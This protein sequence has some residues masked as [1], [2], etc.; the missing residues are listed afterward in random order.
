MDIQHNFEDFFEHA[1]C[2]Y[3]TLDAKGTILEANSRIAT[4]M[5]C[6]GGSLKGKRISDLLSVGGR[7]YYETHL[8]PL[9]RIQGYFDEISL[10]LAPSNAPRIQVLANAYER[11]DDDQQPLFIR[12]TIFKA[13]DRKVYEQNLRNDK[14]I[15]EKRLTN[16]QTMSALREQFI[17]VLGHDLRNPLSAILSGASFLDYAVQDKDE[18]RIVGIMKS[19]ARRMAGMIDDIMDFARGR[20]GEGMQIQ[21]V[22]TETKPVLEQVVNE[23]RIAYPDRT[24][25]TDF[26]IT[27]P[28]EC[29]AQRIGQ[30]LSNLLA[31]AL[32]H[33]LANAPV[34]VNGFHKDE[35]FV[36][37][38]SN[39]GK[40]IAPAALEKLFHPF[41][42]ESSRPTQHG[43]GL[44]LYIAAEIARAH[45]GTIT[46]VSNEEETR[47]T[48]AMQ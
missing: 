45:N 12:V 42:R 6:D 27:E 21:R 11:R 43:L 41:T 16:E 25:E 26:D 39:S 18:R 33:G 15:A 8:W 20:L 24:I 30:L 5:G 47:F 1:L 35:Y 46:V 10:E 34:L 44:G 9:L 22:P 7:I 19:S 37:S 40:P 28:V 23:L 29:D 48:F 32:T 17:A 4:W 3:L 31:N 13:T 14:T 36:L 38:V 2:G